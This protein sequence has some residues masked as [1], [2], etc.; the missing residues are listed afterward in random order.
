MLS[1]IQNHT[2]ASYPAFTNLSRDIDNNM[3][4]HQSTYIPSGQGLGSCPPSSRPIACPLHSFQD[5]EEMAMYEE[6]KMYYD[7]KTWSMYSRIT[8][9]RQKQQEQQSRTG[10]NENNCKILSRARTAGTDSMEEKDFSS[11]EEEIFHI[12]I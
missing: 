8:E 2:V 4:D 10:P 5:Y 1:N 12:E 3:E 6:E 9:A 7:S 11:F